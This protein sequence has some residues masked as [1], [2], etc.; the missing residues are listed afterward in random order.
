MLQSAIGS[1]MK[2]SSQVN[3]KICNVFSPKVIIRNGSPIIHS[4]KVILGMVHKSY[5]HW[6]LLLKLICVFSSR[7]SRPCIYTL[8]YM[9]KPCN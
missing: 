5:I 9:N 6:R 7:A 1:P 2:H 3:I 8:V 4:P